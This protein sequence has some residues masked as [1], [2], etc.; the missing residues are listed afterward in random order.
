MKSSQSHALKAMNLYLERNGN[1]N[2]SK[3]SQSTAGLLDATKIGDL[4]QAKLGLESNSPG[5]MIHGTLLKQATVP[6]KAS[7]QSALQ[8]QGVKSSEQPDQHELDILYKS[9]RPGINED[10]RYALQDATSFYK[11]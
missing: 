11:T 4:M 8:S 6:R 2:K 3:T 10:Q 9:F 7:C 1:R 5:K